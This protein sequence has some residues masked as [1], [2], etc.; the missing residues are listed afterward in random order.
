MIENIKILKIFDE[1]TGK[2]IYHSEHPTNITIDN[3]V[4]NVEAKDEN[5]N[6]VECEEIRPKEID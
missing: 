1:K 3:H 2:L 6:V 4:Y 5:G